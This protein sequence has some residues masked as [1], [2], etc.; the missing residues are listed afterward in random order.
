MEKHHRLSIWYVFIAIWI[1]LILQNVIAQRFTV[2]HIPYSEFVRA[3]QG[4]RVGEVAI[5]QDWI[6]GKMKGTQDGR[7][8]EK[9]FSTVRVD[10]DL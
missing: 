3:P 5:T 9:V 6:Q 10:P 1:V 4:G 7:E 2:E 8:V